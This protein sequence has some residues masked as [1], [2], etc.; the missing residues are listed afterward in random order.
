MQLCTVVKLHT[1]SQQHAALAQTMRV[2][3]AACN[4]ISRL[5][6]ETGTFRKFPLQT[7]CYHSVKA[8]TKLHANHVIRALAKVADAYKRDTRTLR[9]FAPLGAVELDARLL[10]WDVEAQVCNIAT[11]QGR[12]KIPFLCSKEQKALL[13]GKRGQSDLLLRDGV[14]YLSCPLDVPE[15]EPFKPEGVIGVDLGLVNVATDSEGHRYTGEP[16][17]RARRKY[18]RLR[19]LLQPRKTRSARKHLQKTRRKESRFVRNENHRISKELVQN[20]LLRKKAL[21]VELLTGIRNRGN[22]LHRAF[23]TKLHNWAFLQL[24][25]FLHYKAKRAGVT[26]IEVDPRYSSQTCS[27][28]QHCE[29]ANRKSQESFCCLQCGYQ[30]NADVNAAQNLAARAS[31]SA[32]LLFQSTATA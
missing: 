2:C 14:F 13:Q 1:N 17:Q 6:F 7:L 21:A 25:T 3:N 19:Q 31:L 8:V 23:R 12:L 18:R 26:V 16:V 11:T 20:A 22:G 27:Q 24:K 15:A 10:D 4:C 30:T 29:R 5:A 9:A 32:G 28:C